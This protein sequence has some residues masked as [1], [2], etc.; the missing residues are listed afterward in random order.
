[1]ANAKPDGNGRRTITAASSSDGVTIVPIVANPTSHAIMTSD[2]STG[3][4]NGNNLDNAMLD[5]NSQ[6][7]WTAL[8]SDGSGRIIEVYGDP[9]GKG[10]LTDSN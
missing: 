10:L 7:V 5:E 2:A 8:A 9:V 6:A 1:M 3:S 4:D